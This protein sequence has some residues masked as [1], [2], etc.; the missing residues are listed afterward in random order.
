M[1]GIGLPE[2]I[3]IL[4]LALIVVG[5]DKLPDLARSLAKGIM[6]LKKTAEGLKQQ[7]KSEG[8]PLDDIRPDLEDAAKSFKSHMLEHPDKGKTSLFP[9]DGVNPPADG[10]A[11]AYE[12]LTKAGID[13][14]DVPTDDDGSPDEKPADTPT[15]AVQPAADSSKEEQKKTAATNDS[16]S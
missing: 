8:N 6:E 10:A 14:G 1:F 9:T 4:A 12:E 11:Q 5:P 13:P 7:L 2:M 15:K 16:D 3:L